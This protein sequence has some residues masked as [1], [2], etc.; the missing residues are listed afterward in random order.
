MKKLSALLC[1]ILVAVALSA[2]TA[3]H[4]DTVQNYPQEAPYVATVFLQPI[5]TVDAAVVQ[6]WCAEVLTYNAGKSDDEPKVTDVQFEPDADNTYRVDLTINHIPDSTLTKTAQPFKLIYTQ[7]L[8][9]PLVLLPASSD[10]NYYVGFTS[11]RRHSSS[12]ADQVTKVQA[13]QDQAGYNVYLWSSDKTIEFVD[14]YPNRTLYIVLTIAGAAL[15]GV[16]V[17]LVSRYC[18]CK[19][20][21]YQL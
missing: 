1:M 11:E 21:K 6:N 2:C 8:Y 10:F 5:H 14:I 17:F 3:F 4:G 12:N 9:N 13:T 20:R 19:K 7:R 15:V 18:D 16:V